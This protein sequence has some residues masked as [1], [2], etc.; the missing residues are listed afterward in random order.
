MQ[1]R[2]G[3]PS[4]QRLAEQRRGIDDLRNQLDGVHF[5]SWIGGCRRR[6]H[7][8]AETEKQDTSRRWVQQKRQPRLAGIDSH[9]AARSFL[10]AVVDAKAAHALGIFYDAHGGH[11]AFLI[12]HESAAFGNL[13]VA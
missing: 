12:A 3:H 8:S 6:R 10:L 1:S 2:V 5:E 7:A 4:R 13:H 9:R 11:D